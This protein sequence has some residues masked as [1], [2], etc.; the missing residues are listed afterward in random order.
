MHI[1]LKC[2]CNRAWG[3]LSRWGHKVS[4]RIQGCNDKWSKVVEVWN[5]KE[6]LITLWKQFYISLNE[7][8][9]QK[10]MFSKNWS[11]KD[12]NLTLS[13]SGMAWRMKFAFSP[14]LSLILFTEFSLTIDKSTKVHKWQFSN[15]MSIQ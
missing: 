5:K 3:W 1:F 2:K 9:S 10:V 7:Y 8:R 14:P 12:L 11:Q 13:T 6:L 15:Y 4:K